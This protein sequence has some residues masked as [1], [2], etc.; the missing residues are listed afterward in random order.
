MFMQLEIKLPELNEH[1]FDTAKGTKLVLDYMYQLN[2]QLRYMLCHLDEENLESSITDKLDSI[3]GLKKDVSDAVKQDAYYSNNIVINNSLGQLGEDIFLQGKTITL[4]GEQIN[5]NSVNISQNASKIQLAEVRIG[6]AEVDISAQQVEINS[7][8]SRISNAE[9]RIDGAE[10]QIEL[11]ANQTTVDALGTRVS[12]AEVRIDGAEAEIELKVSKNGVIAAINLTTEAATI[13]A[14]KINLNGYVT[15]KQLEAEL[16]NIEL[17][18]NERIYTNTL[19]ANSVATGSFTLSGTNMSKLNKTFLTSS[20]ISVGK[21][22]TTVMGSSGNPM[23]ITY[24]SSVTISNSD[25]DI[26]YVG[27]Y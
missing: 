1:S 22:T 17:S 21:A 9:V 24:V 19:Q 4:Q 6:Q 18:F 14:E 5:L 23:T 3:E 8:G 12:S 10:A 7:Q 15:A 26:Y 16:E 11:K 27:Y 2:R 25:D 13:Q 20:K